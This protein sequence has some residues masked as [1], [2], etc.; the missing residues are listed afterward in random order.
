L[1][2]FAHIKKVNFINLIA[3][4]FVDLKEIQVFLESDFIIIPYWKL[5]R[6]K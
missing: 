5:R 6:A 2:S 1:Q 4:G 3:H